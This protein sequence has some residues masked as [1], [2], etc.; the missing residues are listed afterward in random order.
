MG[1][2]YLALESFPYYPVSGDLTSDGVQYSTEVSTTDANTDVVVLSD[3]IDVGTK[4]K[5]LWIYFNVGCAFKAN[6]SATA[7]IKWKAQARNEDGTWTDLFSYV[8]YADIGTSYAGNDKKM[9]GN[10]TVVSTLNQL[11]IDFRVIF[12]CNEANE[13][14]AKLKNSTVIKCGYQR[15][16][17]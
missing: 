6:A 1:L 5:L 11:P 7:D 4:A 9:E 15:I 3:T 13:G 12:Q 2:S 8:T 17:G 16:L 14:R 10:A